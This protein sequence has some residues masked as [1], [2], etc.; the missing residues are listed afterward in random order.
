MIESR[1]WTAYNAAQSEEKARF[2]VLLA[3]LCKGVPETEQVMGRPRLP[4]SDMVFASAFKVYVGFSSRRFTT[5][6]HEAYADGH[7]GSTP[8]F[9]SV[10]RYL[11]D[12]RLT[13]ILKELVTVSSLPLKA[14][15][16]DFAVDA[17]G[18]STCTYERWRDAKYG[19]RMQKRD[20]FKAHVMCGVKT[21][22]VTAVDISGR[23]VHDSRLFAP[24]LKTTAEHFDLSEVSADRAYLSREILD[25]V[26][27]AGAT[28]FIPFKTTTAVP[29]DNGSIW[30]K[31]YHYFMFNRDA[32]LEH[33]HKISNVESAFS[34]I[35]G[36]FGPAVRS[37]SDVGQVNEVLCKVLCH[38]ICVLVL[39]MHELGIEPAF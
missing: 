36:K 3:D 16:V 19:G 34:M 18:F 5:D 27:R 28:P 24:L 31:M 26:E 38:N 22:V 25:T 17:T 33:F 35:K 39:A 30:S 20:W 29:K 14:V 8:H 37:K 32:Y 4:L 12:P 21:N 11:S 13:P 6:L 23:T 2:A 15:E 1:D 7:I 9:N 10:S